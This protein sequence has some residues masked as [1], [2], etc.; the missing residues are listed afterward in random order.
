M[1]TTTLIIIGIIALLIAYLYNRN[2][3]QPHGTYDNEDYG[4]SGS[5]GGNPAYD[6]ENYGSSGS[7]GGSSQTAHDSPDFKSGG[8]IGGQ[9]PSSANNRPHVGKPQGSERP[10]HDSRDFNSGGSIGGN[11][12]RGNKAHSSTTSTSNRPKPSSNQP[13]LRGKDAKEQ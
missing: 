1:D 12:S 10:R 11:A 6:D 2:R 13:A 4:S 8:S 9:R 5:I 7:I 3:V